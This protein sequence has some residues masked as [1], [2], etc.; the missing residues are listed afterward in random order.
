MPNPR[1]LPVGGRKWGLVA[2]FGDLFYRIVGFLGSADLFCPFVG[3]PGFAD[4]LCRLL[5]VSGILGHLIRRGVGGGCSYCPQDA[6]VV[7]SDVL[8]PVD[9]RGSV[10]MR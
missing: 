9:P 7:P 6:S 5:G 3:F 2:E 8:S 4:S 10:A 1:P